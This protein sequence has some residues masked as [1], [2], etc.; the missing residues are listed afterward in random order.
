[1][2]LEASHGTTQGVKALAQAAMDAGATRKEVMEALRVA[3]Y[4]TVG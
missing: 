1:M 2:A 4:I 3:Q